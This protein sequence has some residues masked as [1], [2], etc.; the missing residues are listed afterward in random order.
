[1]G[2]LEFALHQ[3]D[4]RKFGDEGQSQSIRLELK[5]I[6]QAYGIQLTYL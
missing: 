3:L 6:F 5:I 4:P 1:M 2:H